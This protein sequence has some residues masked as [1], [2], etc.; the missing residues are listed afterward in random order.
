MKDVRNQLEFLGRHDIECVIVGGVAATLHGSTIPTTDLDVCYS[1]TAINLQSLARALQSVNARLR[2]APANLPFLLDA[3]T[4]RKGLNFTFV[5]DVGDLDLLG[6]VRGIGYYE[7]VIDGASSFEVL[8]YEFK[9]IALDKLILAKQTA[10]R[11]K[12]LVA[13]AEL[14]AILSRKTSLDE[15]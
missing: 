15:Q 2:N 12:D 10:G 6:E 14:E 8:G 13:V 5:T 9:V 7:K 3:E 1:R 11:P 4:L